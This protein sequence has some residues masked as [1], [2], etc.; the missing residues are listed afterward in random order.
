M[1][2]LC[3]STGPFYVRGLSIRGL[4]CPPGSPGTSP[5]RLLRDQDYEGFLKILVACSVVL[6]KVVLV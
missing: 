3:I 2:G 6:E 4:R 1:C 5:L